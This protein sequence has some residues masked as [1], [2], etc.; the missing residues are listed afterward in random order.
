MTS[1]VMVVEIH[2]YSQSQ[3]IVIHNVKNTY[4]K[5]GLFC[6]RIEKHPHPE[7]N[8]FPVQHIFRV[9]EYQEKL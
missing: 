3:P 6:V 5:D 4:T 2:L 8:K 9:K 7:Y 1:D